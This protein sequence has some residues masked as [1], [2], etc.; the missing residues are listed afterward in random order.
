METATLFY[1]PDKFDTVSLIA[2]TWVVLGQIDEFNLVP[3]KYSTTAAGPLPVIVYKHYVIPKER[4]LDF[5]KSAASSNFSLSAEQIHKTELL[6]ELC[7]SRLHPSTLFMREMLPPEDWKSKLVYYL[8]FPKR[9]SLNAYLEKQHNITGKREAFIQANSVHKLLSEE[10]SD[11]PFFFA[12]TPKSADLVVYCYLLE[13]LYYLKETPHVVDSLYNFPNLVDFLKRM[14]NLIEHLKE[15][16]VVCG[17]VF[18]YLD[19]PET[20]AQT[21]PKIRLVERPELLNSIKFKSGIQLPLKRR[22]TYEESFERRMYVTGISATILVF[23]ILIK[24]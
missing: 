12:E 4:V 1:Q 2:Q 9:L 15:S 23:L 20:V 8:K 5:L 3:C 22:E 16:R 11:K 21:P 13:E 24:N 18:N 7:Q 6:E 14:G 19:K 10:L 17:T